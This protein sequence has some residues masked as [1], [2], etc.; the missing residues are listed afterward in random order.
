ML[1]NIFLASCLLVTSAASQA[2]L[3]SYNGFERASSS[4]IMTGG[5][6]EWLK[7]DKTAG[8][9]INTAL[10][11]NKTWR[12]ASEN[13]ID[14]MFSAFFNC[15]FLCNSGAFRYYKPVGWSSSEENPVNILQRLLGVTLVKEPMCSTN[16]TTACYDPNDPFTVSGALHQ[17]DEVNKSVGVG[18]VLDDYTYRA[19]N[20]GQ[21]ISYRS[22]GKMTI[23]GRHNWT[24]DMSDSA[25]GVAL[26]RTIP[27]SNINPVTVPGSISL[28][29][30]GFVALGLRSRKKG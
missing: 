7:W 21:T 14:A 2:A 19:I 5:G 25:L 3:I 9:S 30:L 12:L 28:L 13:E 1:K 20:R 23:T 18:E 8:Q 29:A 4:D 22:T 6:L 16:L 24:G 10:S 11:N 15:G 27:S 17:F 26:V